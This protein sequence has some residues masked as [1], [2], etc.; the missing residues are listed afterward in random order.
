MRWTA[1]LLTLALFA[2]AT[3]QESPRP[4][5][6]GRQALGEMVRRR[7]AAGGLKGEKD[8]KTGAA[9]LVVADLAKL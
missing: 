4:T 5:E 2:P 1:T 8:P 3:A 9:V 6:V 7:F